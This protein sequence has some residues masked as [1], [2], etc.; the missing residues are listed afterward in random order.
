MKRQ[1]LFLIIF[2][3]GLMCVNAQTDYEMITFNSNAT[4]ESGDIVYSKNTEL[5]LGA[6]IGTTPFNKKSQ[7]LMNYCKSIFNKESLTLL[8]G[9]ATPKDENSTGY[10]PEKQN[11]PTSGTFYTI[12][13]SIDGHIA[14]YVTISYGKPFYIVK[15]SDR[16]CLPIDAIVLKSDGEQPTIKYLNNDYTVS[17]TFKGTVEFDVVGGETYYIFSVGS[18]F[19]LG[20]YVFYF[21]SASSGGGEGGDYITFNDSSAEYICLNLWD[22]NGDHQLS[23]AEAAAVKDIGNAFENNKDVHEFDELRYFTGLTTI[24]NTAFS[25]CSGLTS[26]TIPSSVTSISSYAFNGC[27]GLTSISVES[28]NTSY[29]SRN[30]CNAIIETATNTLIKGCNNTTI[31]SSVTSIGEEAFSGCSGLTSVIIPSGVTSIGDKA[32]ANC[33]SLTGVTIPEGVTSIGESAFSSCISLTNV[34]IPSSVKTIGNYMFNGC[35]GLTGVSIPLGVESIGNYSFYSCSSLASVIIPSSVTSIGQ[36]AFYGCS[37]LTSVTI[38]RGVSS[39][40]NYAFFGCSGLIGV[41]I[42]S[43]VKSIGIRVFYGCSG[44]TNVTI[45]EGVTSI[46]E[47]V[48][49]G[50]PKITTINVQVTDYAAFCTNKV[51]GQIKTTIDKPIILMTDEGKE[52]TEFVIPN[53]AKT[54]GDDAFDNCCGLMSVTIPSSVTSIDG[55]PFSRCAQL[56]L[57]SINSNIMIMNYSTEYNFSNIFGP[58][59]KTYTIGEDVTAIGSYVFYGCSDLASVTIPLGVTRIGSYSFAG[60]SALTSLPLPSS[61]KSI[62]EGAFST[63]TSLT[64]ITIPEGVSRISEKAF[65]GCSGLASV[66]IPSSVTSIGQS[67]FYGCSG[68]ASVTIPSSV[69]SIGQS[70][71]YGCSGLTSVTI[72]SSVTSIGESAFSSCISLTN[73][74][75][76]LSVKTIGNYMFNGCSGLTS[77]SIPLGVES[78]GN[79]SFYSCSSLSSVIIPSSVTSIGQS[80]FSGCSGL[81]SVTFPSSVTSIGQDAFYQCTGL[82]KVIVPDIAAWCRISFGNNTANPLCYANNIY[83][84]EN[85]EI[86]DLIIPEGVTS[87][88]FSAFFGCSSLTSVTIPESVTSIGDYAF[89]DCRALRSITNFSESPQEGNN[90]I[91]LISSSVYDPKYNRDYDV[92]YYAKLHVPPGMKYTY[93]YGD[94]PWCLFHGAWHP[95]YGYYGYD[96]IYDDAVNGIEPVT[97]APDE[98]AV[99]GIYDTNGKALPAMR[100]GINII[101]YSDGTTKKVIVK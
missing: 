85:T 11:L 77:V 95:Q 30:N 43:S 16:C 72:P 59:V 58:Q 47:G 82:T 46:G 92:Y 36:S 76:P 83:S 78:I 29:D 100:P 53:G 25:G 90:S 18:L 51:I 26:V 40:G 37:S 10:T 34:S 87:I 62:G 66:T 97:T 27:T 2:L 84:D 31:P 38:G 88:G 101:R 24:A 98:V 45:G 50:C 33:T 9:S 99:T 21:D 23:Y 6:E 74:S 19:P 13:P 22:K 4:Y 60:C 39:I 17:P 5:V 81:T 28:G 35:S 42:P 12:T 91:F 68:L 64:S 56:T 3:M 32:F 75:I 49:T 15:Y 1:L 80:A 94:Y 65:Y 71:F 61:L 20:G 96:H 54:I 69:T 57:V 73:V 67:A 48:F 52:I 63:C 55:T 86:T 79:Y 8:Y 14:A 89:Y 41:T 7:R 44:L 70:A 93:Y